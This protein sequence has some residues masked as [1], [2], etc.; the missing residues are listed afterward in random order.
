MKHQKN[1]FKIIVGG[2]I[3][4]AIIAT[5][6][7]LIWQS[8]K[9]SQDKASITILCHNVD[10]I[11]TNPLEHTSQLEALSESEDPILKQSARRL[12]Q[13]DK[14]IASNLKIQKVK[15]IFYKKNI[16]KIA[17]AVCEVIG[18]EKDP[19][20]I[21][22]NFLDKNGDI[23]LS[24][25]FRSNSNNIE[26]LDKELRTTGKDLPSPIFYHNDFLERIKGFLIE[27]KDGIDESS[28]GYFTEAWINDLKEHLPDFYTKMELSPEEL[29]ETVITYYLFQHYIFVRIY[30]EGA[31]EDLVYIA[32]N[33]QKT[34]ACKDEKLAQDYADKQAT[35]ISLQDASSHLAKHL[36]QDHDYVMTEE[37]KTNI[38]NL[39]DDCSSINF[40]KKAFIEKNH[41]TITKHYLNKEKVEKYRDLAIDDKNF[42]QLFT[43]EVNINQLENNKHIIIHSSFHADHQGNNTKTF[44]QSAF[45]LIDEIKQNA[46]KPVYVILCLDGGF[47]TRSTKNKLSLDTVT[48]I[49][50]EAGCKIIQHQGEGINTTKKECS[51]MQIHMHKAG[52]Q[53]KEL[54]DII[55][56]SNNITI[57]DASLSPYTELSAHRA[58]EAKIAL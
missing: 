38:E 20:E 13:V 42:N 40:Y 25:H 44:L 50:E 53:E 23:P 7:V 19:D 28:E 27:A 11:N 46:K 57:V 34:N 5:S 10:E 18:F 9:T 15:Q 6:S 1:L 51:H 56:V 54:N 12:L 29:V 36:Y 21:V 17:E 3:A 16:R 35:F 47:T 2:S 4:L 26:H 48:S 22:T 39:E 31:M 55:I 41:Y 30:E 43:N 45:G 14:N 37:D 33:H 32:E 24:D 52:K 49:I 8:K 58:I